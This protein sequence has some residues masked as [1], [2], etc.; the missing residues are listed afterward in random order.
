MSQTGFQLTA[1]PHLGGPLS[2]PKVMWNVVW[3][4]VPVVAAGVYFFG[5]SAVFVILAATAGALGAEALA[6]GRATLHDGSALI[7][8]V[9]L[10]LCLPPGLP[11]WMAFLGG[12]FSILVGKMAFGGLGHNVFNPALLGRA[13]LQAAFP[14][15]ITTWPKQ[16][17]SWWAWRGDT[18]ALPFT[19]PQVTPAMTSATPLGLMKFEH[20]PTALRQLMLGT[21]GGSIGETCGVLLLLCGAWMV[22]RGLL[23]WRI[24]VAMIAATA[25]FAA[26]VHAVAPSRCP[27]ALFMVFSGGLLLG[28]VYMATDPVTSP[29]S[30]LG[31][32]VFGAGAGI[33]VV[34]IRV[35]GGLPEGV[36]YAILLMNALTP[37]INRATEPRVFGAR[38]REAHS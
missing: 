19:A 7:T 13:F 6:K 28:A 10:G 17:A 1:S 3:S 4:L 33:F 31:C 14:V 15:A 5:P 26:I 12:A 30:H 24:P 8:G 27:D 32:W 11:M 34:L 36:M 9:L 21:T 37:F 16:A 29:V 2:L 35:W 23:N 20:T 18:F 25:V 22:W 38:R